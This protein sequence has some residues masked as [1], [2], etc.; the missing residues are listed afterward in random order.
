M[1][2][3]TALIELNQEIARMLRRWQAALDP[4]DSRKPRRRERR[5]TKDLGDAKDPVRT[6]DRDGRPQDGLRTKAQG[7]LLRRRRR[8]RGPCCRCRTTRT[9]GATGTAS[10]EIRLQQVSQGVHVAQLAIL[11]TEQMRVR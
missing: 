9:A 11:H 7:L 5:R 1:E 2:E 10:T 4:G 6:K 3:T 8:I